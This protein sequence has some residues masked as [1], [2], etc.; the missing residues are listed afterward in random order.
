LLAADAPPGDHRMPRAREYP[1]FNAAFES[2]WARSA[3]M[4]ARSRC[5][6]CELGLDLVAFH[7][8]AAVTVKRRTFKHDPLGSDGQ[9][10]GDK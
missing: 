4:I 7:L 10:S 2:R 9:I 5:Q 8:R 6:R 1:Q 3:R